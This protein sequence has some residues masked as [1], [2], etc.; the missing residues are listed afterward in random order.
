MASLIADF[1]FFLDEGFNTINSNGEGKKRKG[2]KRSQKRPSSVWTLMRTGCGS[3]KLRC[4]K[5]QYFVGPEKPFLKLASHSLSPRQE[6]LSEMTLVRG[7]WWVCYLNWSLFGCIFIHDFWFMYVLGS[8]AKWSLLPL[9]R[10]IVLLGPLIS[11]TAVCI[12][13]YD[14]N[15]DDSNKTKTTGSHLVSQCSFL[16]CLVSFGRW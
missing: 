14:D 8:V 5:H 13:I 4:R 15:D 16:L 12:K 11:L 1:F 9:L 2:K 3:W 10:L 6:G 7:L